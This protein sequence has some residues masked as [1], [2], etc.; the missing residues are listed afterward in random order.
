MN[1]NEITAWLLVGVI[2]EHLMSCSG[3]GITCEGC[4]CPECCGPCGA[5]AAIRDHEFGHVMEALILQYTGNWPWIGASGLIDWA[6]IE[7]HWKADC[8]QCSQRETEEILADPGAMA[9]LAESERDIA[10]GNL[11][12]AEDLREVMGQRLFE[13]GIL[14]PKTRPL[15]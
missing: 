14:I 8:E 10:A 9:D 3:P 6:Q 5:L 2:N 13:A 7:V 12:P 15:R 1:T 11:V 4:C